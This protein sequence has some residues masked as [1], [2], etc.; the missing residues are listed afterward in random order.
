MFEIL[1]KV[2]PFS[3]EPTQLDPVRYGVLTVNPSDPRLT[4]AS[5]VSLKML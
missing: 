3:E 4:R 5:F 1:H 2:N